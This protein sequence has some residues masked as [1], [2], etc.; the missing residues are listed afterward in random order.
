[1][2]SPSAIPTA[3]EMPWPSGPVVVSMPGAWPYSGW[4]ARRRA[5][6]AEVLEVV[7]RDAV[8]A[9]GSS[10]E[11]RSIEA[12]PQE[13]TKRS[14]P[15]QCGIGRRVPH[16]ARVEHV[17]DRRQRHRRARD[18]PSWPSG[19]RPWTG[20]GSCSRTAR[21]ARAGPF[22][23]SC[24]SSTSIACAGRYRLTQAR[25]G[26]A[27]RNPSRAGR[28][29]RPPER[30]RQHDGERAEAPPQLRA[31]VVHERHRERSRRPWPRC[32]GR[33]ATGRP[34]CAA[35]AGRAPRA[36][37]GAACAARRTAIST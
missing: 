28:R 18:G 11:Y 8:A 3:V 7:E 30:R 31:H 17:G 16:D 10:V 20:C 24:G 13:R 26:A 5:E 36:R 27:A 34:T 33:S 21:P 14:R 22:P 12:W 32:S 37:A 23:P 15:G 6:L 4:P 19:R 1:M 35:S 29:A 2:R 9:S 25:L